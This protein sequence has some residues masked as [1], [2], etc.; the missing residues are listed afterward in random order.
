MGGGTKACRFRVWKDRVDIEC[1]R[2]DSSGL[3]S[4]LHRVMHSTESSS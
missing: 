3:C 4:H 2:V 1:V